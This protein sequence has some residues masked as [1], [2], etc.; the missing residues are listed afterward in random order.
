MAFINYMEMLNLT[1]QIMEEINVNDK[2]FEDM[3]WRKLHEET[4]GLIFNSTDADNIYN[5]VCEN[6]GLSNYIIE[7]L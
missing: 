1:Y 4:D 5:K 6:Y 2:D 7:R 3:F